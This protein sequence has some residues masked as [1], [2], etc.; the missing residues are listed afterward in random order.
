MKSIRCRREGLILWLELNL[1]S[2]HSG[3][4]KVMACYVSIHEKFSDENRE[5]K[6]KFLVMTL[7]HVLHVISWYRSTSFS[8]FLCHHSSFLHRD[9]NRNGKCYFR[10][11]IEK[12]KL[13]DFSHFNCRRSLKFKTFSELCLI[14]ILTLP[15]LNSSWKIYFIELDKLIDKYQSTKAFIVHCTDVVEFNIAIILKNHFSF[16]FPSFP[17]PR[18]RTSTS[19]SL[20]LNIL[21]DERILI[22]SSQLIVHISR[23]MYRRIRNKKFHHWES[24]KVSDIRYLLMLAWINI[25]KQCSEFLYGRI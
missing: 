11:L 12:K 16:L 8:Y 25:W 19:C 4:L 6:C 13:H 18:R 7:F 23:D 3:T 1:K 9:T 10:A 17:S 21:M 22:P 2:W 24:Y 20:S 5:R 15:C 14:F